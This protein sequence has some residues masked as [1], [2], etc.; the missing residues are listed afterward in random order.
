MMKIFKTKKTE[1]KTISNI[2]K[3]STTELKNVIG[4]TDV[5]VNPSAGDRYTGLSTG[6]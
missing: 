4:G 1:V 6:R 5:V 2:T 3:L